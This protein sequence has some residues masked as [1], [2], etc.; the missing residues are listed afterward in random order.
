MAL[1]ICYFV[2]GNLLNPTQSFDQCEPMLL[3]VLPAQM[4]PCFRLPEAGQRACCCLPSH[5]YV[6]A[7][8]R[9]LVVS[10][11]LQTLVYSKNSPGGRDWVTRIVSDWKFKRIIPAHFGAPVKAGPQEFR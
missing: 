3:S 6:P 1:Q 4:P 7:V 9:K 5:T 2:P 11:V 10:P 8:A